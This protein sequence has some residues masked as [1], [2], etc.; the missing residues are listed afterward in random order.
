MNGVRVVPTQPIQIWNSTWRSL[1]P[2]SHVPWVH[3]SGTKKVRHFL[4]IRSYKFPQQ[5]NTSPKAWAK[6]EEAW[7]KTWAKRG[8]T[9]APHSPRQYFAKRNCNPG[10]SPPQNKTKASK[11]TFET[12]DFVVECPS[13]KRKTINQHK[14]STRKTYM[15]AVSVTMR[16]GMLK[17]NI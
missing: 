12:W 9:W 17:Q 10:G 2:E 14:L 7:A 6:P 15:S 1:Q 3:T 13:R 8:Q 4:L 16:R 11:N 5:I